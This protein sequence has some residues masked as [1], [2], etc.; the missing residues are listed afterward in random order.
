MKLEEM[1]IE[2]IVKKFIPALRNP[3]TKNMVVKWASNINTFM[4]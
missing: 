4:R 3:S 1:T 2:E